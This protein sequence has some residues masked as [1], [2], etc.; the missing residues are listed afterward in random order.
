MAQARGAVPK[1]V[2]RGA[3]LTSPRP[4]KPVPLACHEHSDHH[5]GPSVARRP[6]TPNLNPRTTAKTSAAGGWPATGFDL[7]RHP[8]RLNRQ[9]RS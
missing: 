7:N 3:P 9:L 6:L 2:N 5:P 8:A 4:N 1:L